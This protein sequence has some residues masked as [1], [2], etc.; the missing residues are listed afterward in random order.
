MLV[1]LQ[2]NRARAIKL[3]AETA[4][5]FQSSRLISAVI[6]IK[7]LLHAAWNELKA[8]VH[9]LMK[10]DLW[11]SYQRYRVRCLGWQNIKVSATRSR[12]LLR[13]DTCV[14]GDPSLLRQRQTASVLCFAEAYY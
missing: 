12:P 8:L 5:I 1:S 13:P 6:A 9:G 4:G 2:Y 14:E 3:K 7:L 11:K 10:R